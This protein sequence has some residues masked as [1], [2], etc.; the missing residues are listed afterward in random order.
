MIASIDPGQQLATANFL[1]AMTG[2]FT[3]GLPLL[4]IV[5]N[6][7]YHKIKL[8]S[9]TDDELAYEIEMFGW[10]EE[11]DNIVLE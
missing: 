1:L 5:G 8:I 7:S 6:R 10:G 3:F 9:L 2:L 4:L 11:I